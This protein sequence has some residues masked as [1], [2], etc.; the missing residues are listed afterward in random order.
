MIGVDPEHVRDHEQ[1]QRSAEVTDEIGL[2][3]RRRRDR[4]S[5]RASV[6]A[7]HVRLERGD[8]RRRERAADEAAQLGVVG[9]IGGQEEARRV[10]HRAHEAAAASARGRGVARAAERAPDAAAGVRIADDENSS[11]ERSTRSTSS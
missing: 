7:A 4:S 5:T 11:G 10:G 8:G 9:G 1:R 2:A 3:A 6:T